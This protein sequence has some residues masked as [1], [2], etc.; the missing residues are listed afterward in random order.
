MVHGRFLEL[1]CWIY[2]PFLYYTIHSPTHAPHQRLALPYVNKLLTTCAQILR[3]DLSKHRHHGTWFAT[4][5]NIAAA[6]LILAA[7]RSD[8]VPV[9]TDWQDILQT[10][11]EK[12]RYW[13]DEACGTLSA[14]QVIENLMSFSPR[15][16]EDLSSS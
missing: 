11:L 12:L 15:E 5:S 14:V 7:A 6:L 13:A 2:R 8:T 4:R 3:H 10:G 16:R 9:P 1:K